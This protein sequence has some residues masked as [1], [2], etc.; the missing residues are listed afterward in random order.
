M[1]EDISFGRP[2]FKE[3]EIIWVTGNKVLNCQ[4]I[5]TGLS[6]TQPRKKQGTHIT[7]L[8]N[9]TEIATKKYEIKNG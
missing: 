7:M 3:I 5:I 4:R 1:F 9:D 2:Q 6:T 8:S